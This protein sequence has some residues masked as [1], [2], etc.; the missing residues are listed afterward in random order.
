MMH[1]A[2]GQL[3]QEVVTGG[4]PAPPS[5]YVLRE[6]DRTTGGGE[7]PELGFPIVNVQRLAEPGDVEEAAKLQAALQSW[8][9]FAVT[10][11]AIPESLLDDIRE[12][13]KE[14]F[15][16]PSSEKLQ[17]ANQT[18]SGEFQ[19]EGYGIDRVDTADQILDQILTVQPEE[20]RQLRLWPRHPPSLSKLLHEYALRSEQVAKQVLRAMARTLGFDEEFFLGRHVGEKVAS[21][22][23]FTYYPP[24]PRPDLV[25]GLK[26]HTD[27]SVITT[28]LLDRDV[29]GL[30]VL[31]DGRWVGVPVLGRSGEM[32]VVV[33]DEMEIMSNA[34]FRAPTHRVVAGER[35]RM[36]LATFY[37][38]ELHRD[39]EPA[40]ELVGGDRPAMY[41]KVGVKTFADGF[42]DAF[43]RGE[44]TIDF[45]DARV[46]KKEAPR[47]VPGT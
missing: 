43:A 1:E 8:G 46:D 20:S 19:N 22:A 23:R 11:H 18:E 29:G 32:L 42:W 12:E 9:L 40:A 3:V 36:S 24:C 31:R 27:N 16:L 37:Q 13:A 17:Y 7:A 4:L 45:L 47:A 5:R 39:L 44:P 28:L 35:E 10:D 15:H 25:H 26:P 6:K 21:Y 30:Q 41:R 34:A 14:F 2:Q 33:G 38:P